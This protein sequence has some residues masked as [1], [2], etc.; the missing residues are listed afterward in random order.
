[1]KIERLY[2]Q[3]FLSY[4]QLCLDFDK[5]INVIRGSN[6]SGKTNLLEA[7]YLSAIGKTARNIKDKD[8][9]RWG[10]DSNAIIEIRASKKLGLFN[11]EINIDTAIQK[12]IKINSLPISRLSQLLGILNVVYFSPDEMKLIKESPNDRRRFLNISL[13]QQNKNYFYNLTKY[14][15][16]LQQRNKLLKDYKDTPTLVKLVNLVDQSIIP[17]MEYIIKCRMEFIEKLQPFANKQHN[18]ITCKKEDLHIKYQ[19]ENIDFSNIA[20]SMQKVFEVNFEKD[21]KLEY[22][23]AGIHRDDLKI[24][25]GGIDIRKY[26][27]QGQQRTAVLALKLAE[28]FMFHS[29]TGEYPIL[30]LD[31]VLSELDYQRQQALLASIKQVQTII[32]CTEFDRSLLNHSYLDININDIKEKC[33]NA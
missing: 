30:L 28:V 23:T 33:E 7:I 13:S 4:K 2:L 22:T 12:Y 19:T 8:L 10:A 21:R 32:T 9:V 3:N 25:A 14:N 20:S 18:K 31:D 6:A 15:K 27:S 16:L 24:V 29:H 11:I 26:G 17:C 1:M 5:G